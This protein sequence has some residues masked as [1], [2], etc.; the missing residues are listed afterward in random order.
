M[1]K[2]V[3]FS[4]EVQIKTYHPENLQPSFDSFEQLK[5][6]LG[7]TFPGCC[8]VKEQKHFIDQLQVWR[9]SKISIVLGNLGRHIELLTYFLDF[10]FSSQESVGIYCQRW[11]TGSPYQVLDP[12]KEKVDVLFVIEP[13]F[14][15]D[16]LS[17]SA[18]SF[19]VILTSHF[20]LST[21]TPVQSHFYFVGSSPLQIK[22]SPQDKEIISFIPPVFYD[23]RWQP[24]PLDCTT[25]IDVSSIFTAEE[26][27]LRYLTGRELLQDRSYVVK[28]SPRHLHHLRFLLPRKS[29]LQLIQVKWFSFVFYKDIFEDDM[30]PL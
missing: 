15:Q 24:P 23:G 27:Y 20:S 14:G 25:C 21:P 29:V 5:R 16:V 30:S 2:H 3:R 17:F 10:S 9:Q 19:V 26:A 22:C 8:K 4:P 12:R 7:E 6:D 18:N 13:Y 28:F 11:S 1:T